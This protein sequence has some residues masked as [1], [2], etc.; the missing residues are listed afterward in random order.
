M[1]LSYSTT[2]LDPFEKLKLGWLEPEVVSAACEREL[3]DVETRR[4]ALLLWDPR[5]GPSEYFLVENRWR[6]GSYDAG[7]AH[8]GVGLPQDG[9]AV[10][11]VIEDPKAFDTA[12]QL[13]PTGGEGDWGRRGLRLIRRNG[14][15]LYDDG[16]ALIAKQGDG[17]D[18]RKGDA[19]LVWLDGTPSGF[20]VT[21]LTPP[22][23]TVRVKI[24][25][26]RK[27]L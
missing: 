26:N 9:L 25:R 7:I 1:D 21:L 12:L 23:A 24:G 16:R 10:W 14:G 5:R 22:G 3:A 13:P 8:V 18:D 4:K 20:S 27:Y 19:R 6:A 15:L 2:H 17:I 11:H